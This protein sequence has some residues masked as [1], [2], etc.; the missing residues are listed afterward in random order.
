MDGDWFTEDYLNLHETKLHR[1]C[2][3]N[4]MTSSLDLWCADLCK[5]SRQTGHWS[6]VTGIKYRITVL[7]SL[8][9]GQVPFLEFFLGWGWAMGSYI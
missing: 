2:G 5:Q 7:L 4:V 6:L 9:Q 3:T 1:N 8:M